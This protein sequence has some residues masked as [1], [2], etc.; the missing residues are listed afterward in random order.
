[1]KYFAFL[2][3]LCVSSLVYGECVTLK[4]PAT[5]H[6]QHAPP[7]ADGEIVEVDV[8]IAYTEEA[9]EMLEG[10]LTRDQNLHKAVDDTNQH[11]KDSEIPVK[12]NLVYTYQTDYNMDENSS[13]DLVNWR[14]K[15]DGK[16]DE[17]HELRDISGADLCILIIERRDL[18]GAAYINGPMNEAFAFGMVTPW[19]LF[20]SLRHEI[21]HMFGADHDKDNARTQT[22]FG[23][24]WHFHD[25]DGNWHGT[26][27][28]Y[29]GRRIGH[30]SNPDV[31]YAGQP[32]GTDKANN[33][34]WITSRAP[35]IAQFRSPPESDNPHVTV[36]LI[37]V[38]FVR[39]ENTQVFLNGLEIL[40]DTFLVDTGVH[41]IRIVG[42]GKEL[43]KRL[44]II[45]E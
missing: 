35:S 45:P 27:M 7:V 32:T 8:L 13:T 20:H 42:D 14:R 26:I 30:F 38:A 21:G 11:F 23:Y 6:V 9:G 18:C 40:D 15:N 43:R 41:D 2:L 12:L 5:T 29:Q 25:S 33:A 44:T 10:H 28:S 19:C 4:V 24:G 16:A 22:D 1:M 31:L 39:G 36:D 34:K 37:R 3:A 17:V